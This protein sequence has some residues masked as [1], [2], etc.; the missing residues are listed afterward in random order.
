M[1]MHVFIGLNHLHLVID[2]LDDALMESRRDT[3]IGVY[4][5]SS[6]KHIIASLDVHHE[7]GRRHG[8]APNR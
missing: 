7:E 3:L 8:F 4:P 1:A 6:E 5:I 2:R